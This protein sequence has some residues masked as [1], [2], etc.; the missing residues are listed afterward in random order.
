MGQ[1]RRTLTWVSS[2][3]FLLCS[4]GRGEGAKG[5]GGGAWIFFRPEEAATHTHRQLLSDGMKQ[6]LKMGWGRK[7]V[8]LL[9]TC[10]DGRGAGCDELP[11]GLG[12]G[13][14]HVG[15]GGQALGVDGGQTKGRAPDVELEDHA[16]SSPVKH[17][18]YCTC[19][20]LSQLVLAGR[21]VVCL[22][23]RLA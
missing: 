2:H 4:L 13:I 16:F 14:G 21:C 23:R 12:H 7:S 11:L 9:L 20:V 15:D 1:L 18:G 8:D 5:E 3:L 10:R 22:V 19:P 6:R 17:A